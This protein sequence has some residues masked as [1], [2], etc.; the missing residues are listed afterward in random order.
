MGLPS[1]AFRHRIRLERKEVTRAPNGEEQVTWIQHAEVW[2]SVEPLRAREW[3]AAAAQQAST[4][5]R[6]TLRYRPDVTITRAMRVV[7]LPS[8]TV[9]DIVGDPINVKGRD[10]NIELMCASGVGAANG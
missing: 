10:D 3:F 8:G 5:H 4:D 6:V 9:L 1:G 7:W 2:A